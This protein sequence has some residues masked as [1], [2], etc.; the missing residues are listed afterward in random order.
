MSTDEVAARVKDLVV[1]G[2]SA[3]GIGA[4][5]VF[6]STLARDFPAPVVVAQHLDPQRPSNLGPILERHSTVPVVVVSEPTRMEPGKV[7]VV[8]S[9][10][11]VAIMDGEVYLEEDH[12]GRPR[13]SVDRLLSTAA[14]NYGEHLI[15]VIMTGSGSDGAAG[16]VEVKN[17]GGTVIIQNPESAA[18]PSMPLSLPPT[19]VDH[20]AEIEQVAGLLDSL[21]RGLD[22]APPEKVEDPLRE[23]LA[24]VSR[25]A[26][27]DFGQYKTTTIMRRVARRMAVTHTNS[28]RDYGHYLEAHPEEVQELVRAF[29]IKVTGFF[30]DPEAFEYI[31]QS[32]L[33]ALVERGARAGARAA[34]VVCRVRDGRGGLL[35]GAAAGRPARPGAARV[36]REGLRHRPRRERDQLRAPRR[37]P[38]Q[39]LE[40]AAGRLP[41][42]LLRA[43]RPGLPHRQVPAPDG[44]LRPSGFEPRR[45]VPAH[46]PRRR[47]ATC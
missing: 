33:P 29:L 47:A 31:R 46:R 9:N 39:R 23:V 10:R 24:Q 42:A 25:H 2:A 37:L 7:Y 45:P 18:Y 27:I 8:P 41:R 4:L 44:H 35:A 38:R 6:V 12:E 26:D 28:L 30:R 40:R 22:L 20:V 17:A 14:K 36:E 43:V 11:H 32:V 13:P 34:A 19:V 21:L 15:A 1:V 5:S 3:G 16:A